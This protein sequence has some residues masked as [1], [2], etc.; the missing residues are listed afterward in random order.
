[1]NTATVWLQESLQSLHCDLPDKTPYSPD[2]DLLTIV[3]LG[4]WSNTWGVTDSTVMRKWKL[5]FVNGSECKKPPCVTRRSFKTSAKIG[6]K[7]Q[8]AQRLCWKII[9]LVQN[10]LP[11]FNDEWLLNCCDLV[12]LPYLTSFVPTEP[13]ATKFGHRIRHHQGKF[14]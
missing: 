7:H 2:L 1:M 3:C 4:R 11:I 13:I 9:T 8:C 10:K 14:Q 5:L 12:N 6:Q